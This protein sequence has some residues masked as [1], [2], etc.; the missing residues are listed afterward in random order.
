MLLSSQAEING[1]FQSR[2]DGA[3][4]IRMQASGVPMTSMSRNLFIS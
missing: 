4:G 2:G 1:G 3:L